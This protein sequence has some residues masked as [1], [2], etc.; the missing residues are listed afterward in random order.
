V[1]NKSDLINEHDIKELESTLREKLN[2]DKPIYKISSLTKEG[3]GSLARKL[4]D[5][6]ESHQSKL[7]NSP[8]YREKNRELEKMLAFE[9]RKKTAN[10]KIVNKD[11]PSVLNNS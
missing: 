3:C 8:E 6:I 10:A 7:Q 2:W 5:F 1:I 4:M 11:N 9:I